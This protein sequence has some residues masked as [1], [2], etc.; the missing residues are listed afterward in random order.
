MYRNQT[1][2]KC[3]KRGH[4]Q[5]ICRSTISTLN[6]TDYDNQDNDD[7]F[8]DDEDEIYVTTRSGFNTQRGRPKKEPKKFDGTHKTVGKAPMKIDENENRRVRRFRGKATIDEV[9]DYNMWE[10]LMQQQAQVTFAQMLKDPKQQKLLRDAIKR[11]THQE[12]VYDEQWL[13]SDEINQIWDNNEIET[14][15]DKNRT[16]AVKSDLIINGQEIQT[17]IDS[18]AATNII[19]NKLRKELGIEIEKSSKTV[20]K[21]ADGKKV[22]SLGETEIIIEISEQIEIPIKVQVIDSKEKDLI[23]GTTFLQSTKGII[24]FGERKLKIKYNGKQIKIPIYYL[25]ENDNE[26]SESEWEE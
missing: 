7:E 18:G 26:S 12:E 14:E 4:T 2:Q 10:N 9:E 22:P 15:N 25:Q 17:V 20:F 11:K 16:T 8:Y 5:Q 23:L 1:C 21:I 24:D 13:H 6:Y 19:T 3:G